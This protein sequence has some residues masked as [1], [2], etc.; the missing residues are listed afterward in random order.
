M[1]TTAKPTE[2]RKG[3]RIQ[4]PW[5]HGHTVLMISE[6]VD[7]NGSYP[8]IELETGDEYEIASWATPIQIT[9]G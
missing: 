4:E 2:I 5:G 6:S 9:R 8:V 3:D 7:A 1:T